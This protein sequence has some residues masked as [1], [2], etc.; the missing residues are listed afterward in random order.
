VED[1]FAPLTGRSLDVKDGS[2]A[3][4]FPLGPA[5][6]ALLRPTKMHRHPSLWGD[7][8]SGGEAFLLR[9]ISIFQRERR[10]AK[11]VLRSRPS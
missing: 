7:I 2:G 6:H 4:P 9:T 5:R 1:P 8:M 10:A 11:A 3:D